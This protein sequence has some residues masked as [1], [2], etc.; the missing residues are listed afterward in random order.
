MEVDDHRQ[1]CPHYWASGHLVADVVGSYL[2]SPTQQPD[3]DSDLPV[4]VDDC[5]ITAMDPAGTAAYT[6]I[7]TG[8]PCVPGAPYQD[9]EEAEK[10]QGVPS[11]HLCQSQGSQIGPHPKYIYLFHCRIGYSYPRI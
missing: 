4:G 9:R 3:L 11:Q 6:P 8:G 1:V 7:F 5:S 2:A 10:G